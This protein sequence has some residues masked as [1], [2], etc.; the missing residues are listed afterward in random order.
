[1]LDILHF[2]ILILIYSYNKMS[3][4]LH[5]RQIK[6]TLK[7]SREQYNMNINKNRVQ[8]F[9]EMGY[10]FILYLFLFSCLELLLEFI[11]QD[12]NSG[13]KCPGQTKINV[14]HEKWLQ[15]KPKEKIIGALVFFFSNI[16]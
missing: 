7:N 15:I 9:A 6:Q 12:I 11:Y 8:C 4:Y 14:D 2:C 5:Y 1:M 10:L 13:V 16:S 3:R